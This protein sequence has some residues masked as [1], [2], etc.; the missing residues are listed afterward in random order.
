MFAEMNGAKIKL[1]QLKSIISMSSSVKDTI[2]PIRFGG[3][4]INKQQSTRGM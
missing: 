3:N 1:E 2:S 4:Q